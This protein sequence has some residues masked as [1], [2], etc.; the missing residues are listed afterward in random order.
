MT[1]MT[2]A[3]PRFLKAGDVKEVR[4]EAAA[5]TAAA[6][7]AEKE[8]QDTIAAAYAAGLDDGRGAALAEGADAGP[9]IAAALEQL[10]RTATTQ[11]AAAVDVSSR[12]VLASAI[13]IAEWVLRHDL[14]KDSRSVLARLGAAAAAMLPSATTRATVSPH[15]EAAVRTWADGLDIEIV[16]DPRLDPG[17]ARFDN[18]T[19]TV[20]VT[21]AAALRIAAQ[22]MGVDPARGP[23]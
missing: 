10:A 15:D 2:S 5:R 11:R 23:Q 22:A 21:V 16:V 12:A 20:D 1:T 3:A 17:D 8:R 6:L 19:G 13:D 18:G 14:S 9:R 7:L 4:N